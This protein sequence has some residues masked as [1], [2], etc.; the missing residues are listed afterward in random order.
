MRSEIRHQCY[1]RR[2]LNLMLDDCS[3][4]AAA[5][6]PG[7]IGSYHCEETCFLEHAVAV[8]VGGGGGGGRHFPY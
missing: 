3:L 6:E 2:K 5:P 4:S 1:L 7:A 8:V